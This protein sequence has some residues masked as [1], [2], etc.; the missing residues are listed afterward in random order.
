MSASQPLTGNALIDCAR[1]N[2]KQGIETTARL[3]GYGENLE[4]FRNALTEACD[5][6]GVQ[7][8]ELRDLIP[9]TPRIRQTGIEIAPESES[10]L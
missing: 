10:E 3:C 5:G 2:A 7:I 9:P 4:S 1:A 8:D 6:I